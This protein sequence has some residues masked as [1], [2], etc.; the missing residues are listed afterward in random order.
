MNVTGGGTYWGKSMVIWQFK[1]GSC[2]YLRHSQNLVNRYMAKHGVGCSTTV[3]FLQQGG[4]VEPQLLTE[5]GNSFNRAVW[6]ILCW[7][8]FQLFLASSFLLS[9][10]AEILDI[11]VAPK[12]KKFSRGRKH[13]YRTCANWGLL[14][15]CSL[16]PKQGNWRWDSSVYTEAFEYLYI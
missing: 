12:H 7:T 16:A 15:K 14:Q 6:I 11:I 8:F 9:S 5:K 2:I 1:I 3:L 4:R 13:N 10:I